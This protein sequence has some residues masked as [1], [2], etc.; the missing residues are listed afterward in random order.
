MSPSQSADLMLAHHIQPPSF[1]QAKMHA[2]LLVLTATHYRASGPHLSGLMFSG[3]ENS[4]LSSQTL[5][6]SNNSSA[7]E[8]T[9]LTC[10]VHLSEQPPALGV[11]WDP[12]TSLQLLGCLGS[13]ENKSH[14]VR[15]T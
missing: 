4:N 6:A 9:S 2:A 14:K 13:Y 10:S 1:P 7:R 12:S 3:E 8:H 5:L 11:E 15:V